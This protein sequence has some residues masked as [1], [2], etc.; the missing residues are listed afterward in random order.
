MALEINWIAV[1]IAAV[2]YFA[3]VFF[4]YFPKA[5]GNLW[6]KL[7][8]KEGEPKSKIIRDTIIM[9]PTS[10]ITVLSIEIIMDL[11]SMNDVASSLLLTLLLWIGFVGIIGINQNNFNDR[12]IKLF[13]IEYMVY[14]VGFLIVGLILAVWQ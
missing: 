2:I 9:I 7:V 13:L 8:G 14:L 1:I 12:G 10:F 5:F 3:I 4:W 6:L 11:T